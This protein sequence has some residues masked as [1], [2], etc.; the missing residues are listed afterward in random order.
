MSARTII[1]DP[2]AFTAVQLQAMRDWVADC[3]W[4]DLDD[5]QDVAELSDSQVLAGV[6]RHYDGGLAGF[7][8]D[9]QPHYRMPIQ[10]R[11]PETINPVNF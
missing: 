10:W 4:A 6:S 2:A 3:V 11:Q 8:R 9:C 1:L 5:E 7:V